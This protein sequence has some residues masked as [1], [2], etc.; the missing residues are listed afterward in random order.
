MS[1]VQSRQ[2]GPLE[3]PG[4]ADGELGNQTAYD[5]YLRGFDRVPV[6]QDAVSVSVRPPPPPD[7]RRGERPDV[8]MEPR[9]DSYTAREASLAELERLYDE[10]SRPS[11]AARAK[12]K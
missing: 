7:F 3:D 2:A 5:E 11:P 8:R 6:L 9:P 10:Y 4:A 12:R 1:N